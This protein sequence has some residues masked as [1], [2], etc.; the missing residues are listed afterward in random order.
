MINILQFISLSLHLKRIL[1]QLASYPGPT[2]PYHFKEANESLLRM[3]E[4]DLDFAR[5]M[6][7]PGIILERVP[8]GL[9]PWNPPT[10]WAWH[11]AFDP[12]VMPLVPR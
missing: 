2:H 6:R 5:L 4:G 9:A 3:M 11:H 1:D 10:D 7:D 12:G 8:R